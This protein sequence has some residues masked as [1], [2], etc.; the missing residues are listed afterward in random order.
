MTIVKKVK[1][2]KCVSLGCRFYRFNYKIDVHVQTNYNGNSQSYFVHLVGIWKDRAFPNSLTK[3][4]FRNDA[5]KQ[6][7]I[8]IIKKLYIN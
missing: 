8:G 4:I 1:V 6:C 7:R 3:I 5:R 2:S